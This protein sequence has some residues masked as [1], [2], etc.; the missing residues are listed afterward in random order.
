MPA[1]ECCSGRSL[2]Q[3]DDAALDE[4][5]IP[6]RTVLLGQWEEH[7]FR[8]ESRREPRR[9]ET[10]ESRERVY[11]FL[12]GHRRIEQE[13]DELER[14]Q[15]HPREQ[16]I[17][18]VASVIALVEQQV[19]RLEHRRLSRAKIVDAG[20][21]MKNAERGQPCATAMET[22]VDRLRVN[23][24]RPGDLPRRKAAQQAK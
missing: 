8:I 24:E 13:L 10:E 11:V 4:Q 7:A 9:V 15:A 2:R 5:L 20:D 22:A 19:Q 14:V 18:W 12:S 21:V 1:R 6:A 3:M 17:V 16:R 23:Q